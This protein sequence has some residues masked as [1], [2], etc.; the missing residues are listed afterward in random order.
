MHILR[1]IIPTVS[2]RLILV[3]VKHIKCLVNVLLNK[4]SLSY[5]INVELYHAHFIT[6][7]LNK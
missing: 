7:S 6:C 3:H 2:V 1:K 5:E 4:I